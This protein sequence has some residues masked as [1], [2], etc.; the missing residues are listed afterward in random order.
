MRFLVS[1]LAAGC[2][3]AASANAQDGPGPGFNIDAN[4]IKTI[5]RMTD[6]ERVILGAWVTGYVDRLQNNTNTRLRL[7]NAIMVAN[8]VEQA[9][10]SRPQASFLEVLQAQTSG[11]EETPGSR[12]NAERLLNQF[13]GADLAQR[14]ALTAALKPNEADIRA[15]YA[16]P[17]A[18]RL[19]ATYDSIFSPDVHIG[20]KAGQTEVRTWMTTTGRLKQGVG[21]Q[22]FPGGYQDVRGFFLGDHPIV[23]F[24][25]VKPGET[26]GMAFDGLIFVNDRW[27]L[28]PKP[29]RALPD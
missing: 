4:C 12:Q 3:S 19:V 20:P 13:L 27:V 9:C 1:L 14:I 11:G 24:K 17:L 5:E 23:R 6:L 21:L 28:M 15:V 10:R 18:D 2:L 29:W 25:F 16:A 8:N 22:D 26:L 7:D